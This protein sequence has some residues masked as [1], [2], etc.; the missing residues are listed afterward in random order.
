[1]V[2]AFVLGIVES[3]KETEVVDKLR[4]MERVT[5]AHVVYGKYDI[6]MTLEIDDLSEL[7][8]MNTE[9]RKIGGVTSTETLI[10]TIF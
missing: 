2:L 3:G 6:H 5:D 8:R 10:A 4:G 1:M 7:S 9:I